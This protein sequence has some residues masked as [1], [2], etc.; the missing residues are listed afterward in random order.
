M[1]NWTYCDKTERNDLPLPCHVRI[2]AEP[3]K[4]QQ[5]SFYENYNN[6]SKHAEK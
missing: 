4:N 1:R 3:T 6:V 5:G 2:T